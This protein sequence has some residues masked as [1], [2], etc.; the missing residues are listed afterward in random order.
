MPAP[1]QLTVKPLI[2]PSAA[3]RLLLVLKHSLEPQPND[4]PA[5]S[6]RYAALHRQAQWATR[7]FWLASALVVGGTA[8]AGAMLG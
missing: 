5:C 2:F 3:G 4:E 8:V 7:L 6:Q 1:F